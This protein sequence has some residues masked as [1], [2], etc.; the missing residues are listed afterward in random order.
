MTM[1]TIGRK[2]GS[3][4]GVNSKIKNCLNHQKTRIKKTQQKRRS[5][6]RKTGVQC[7]RNSRKDKVLGLNKKK[8]R[9]WTHQKR[10]HLLPRETSLECEI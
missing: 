5:P 8:K 1:P 2:K 4:R 10:C 3:M 6:E 9:T 7:Y